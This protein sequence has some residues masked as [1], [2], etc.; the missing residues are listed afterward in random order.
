MAVRPQPRDLTQAQLAAQEADPLVRQRVRDRP[1]VDDRRV[2]LEAGPAHP[3]DAPLAVGQQ[4]EALGDERAEQRGAIA[5]AV[6]DDGDPPLADEG[7]DFGEHAREHL[8]QARVRLGGDH[9]ERVAA[10]VVHPVVRRGAHGQAQARDVG[11][12]QGPL[13]VV[14]P[15]GPVDG[16]EAQRGAAVGHAPFGEGPPELR[17]PADAGQAAELAPQRLALGRA[18]Q[19]E[20]AAEVRGRVLLQHLR[21]LDPQQRHEKQGHEGGAQAVEGGAEAAVDRPG[22]HE[23]PT[24]HEGGQRQQDPGAGNPAAGP[25]QGGR[26]VE[27][28]QVGEHAVHAPVGGVPV[29][30]HRDRLVVGRG[31][32]GQVW[33]PGGPGPSRRVLRPLSAGG[34]GQTGP[35]W[36]PARRDPRQ[37]DLLGRGVTPPHPREAFPDGLR[38]DAEPLRNLPRRHS[39]RLQAA[40]Q[41]RPRRRQPGPAGGVA[42]RPTQ[43]GEPTHLQPTRVPPETARGATGGARHVVLVRPALL[44][45]ADHGVRLGHLVA[46]GV[47][48]QNDAG[49]DHHAMPMLGS[50]EAAIVDNGRAL[51]RGRIREEV[52]LLSCS[53]HGRSMIAW[54][55]SKKRTGLGL[56][57]PRPKLGRT[58]TSEPY[59]K[60]SGFEASKRESVVAESEVR[61]SLLTAEAQRRRGASRAGRPTAL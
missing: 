55:R 46:D 48:R 19:A 17:G 9:E 57:P 2:L 56:R 47:L 20:H 37:G 7:P 3:G 25:E 50:H 53:R 36:G 32:S 45:Q 11:L 49:D 16:P 31:E 39:L 12:R 58:R 34:P 43:G 26:V 8:H 5:P 27:Q 10:G 42:P 33:V 6:E 21:P 4:V 13:A 18:I 30:R 40:K 28:A 61:S 51:G 29:K 15:D 52:R 24:V 22:D 1:A 54:T 23:D 41:V 14:D 60:R 38:R 59:V 35:V 44:D